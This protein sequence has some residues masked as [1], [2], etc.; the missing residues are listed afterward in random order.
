MGSAMIPFAVPLRFS[1]SL[2]FVCLV[3]YLL[4][5]LLLLSKMRVRN[6]RKYLLV[7]KKKDIRWYFPKRNELVSTS[8]FLSAITGFPQ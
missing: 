2:F 8:S 1:R 6:E 3:L 5:E 4:V 7:K